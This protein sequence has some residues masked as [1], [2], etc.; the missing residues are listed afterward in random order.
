MQQNSSQTDFKPS[1]SS[2]MGLGNTN[3]PQRRKNLLD[4]IQY[5]AWLE[6]NPAIATVE[7]TYRICYIKEIFRQLRESFNTKKKE[8]L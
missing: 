4:G 5:I 7:F 2:E 1:L 6:K 3:L 8:M